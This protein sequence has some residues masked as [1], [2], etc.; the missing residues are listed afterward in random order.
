MNRLPEPHLN[1]LLRYCATL[2]CVLS[3]F[4][5]L[6]TGCTRLPSLQ[7]RS[8]SEAELDTLAT[9]LG[10]AISPQ[11]VK[12]FG[13]S[14]IYPLSDGRDAFVARAQLAQAAER[15]LD[16]QYYIWHKDMT[17]T[18]LFDALYQTANRGVRVRLLLDDNNT[19]G[20]DTLLAALDAHPKIEVRL[21]NPFVFRNVRPLDYVINFGR[22]N[23]RMHNKSF[24]ADS[25]ATIIGGRNI[26]D[27]YF[28]AADG[29]LFADLDVLAV[30]PV[31]Q[32][33]SRD[34]DRYWNS[35]S[36]YQVKGFLPQADSATLAELSRVSLRL[37][38]DSSALAYT[39]ALRNSSFAGDLLRGD[40]N[41]EWAVTHMI[42]DDPI[43][44]LGLAVP[45]SL[46]LNKLKTHM[47]EANSELNLVSPYFVPLN[48]GVETLA[49]AARRGVNVRVL[50]NALESTDVA[51]VHAG[52]A[53]H[54]KSLLRAGVSLY[55]L[56]SAGRRSATK[57][58]AGFAG[59]SSSSL[60][61]K[62]FSVDHLRVFIGSFNFDPRSANLN[63]EMGFVI[64]SPSL[65]ASI[66]SAFADGIPANAY[67][68]RLSE[69]G[70]LYWIERQG[71]TELRHDVEPGT[72]VM[73]RIG[74]SL[75]SLLPID[76][77]L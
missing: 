6:T 63:T 35:N 58:V 31:V 72:S 59:S 32:E 7:N 67:E 75:I 74:V 15:T 3:S 5:F 65:A 19:S 44:G 17:G 2:A 57:Q 51:A 68:V 55:E 41:I 37:K 10:Q 21:F 38:N 9:G 77:L 18:M 46:I 52:Y 71:I 40:L 28:G 13:R 61:S 53:K 73:A 29:V 33:V 11:V 36:S 60:H 24:T 22:A 45:D 16:V 48:K 47:G 8:V 23:R 14:G 62:T 70:E 76:W 27:E 1:I 39:E 26:G 30:G 34:F 50:T 49:E 66:S 43:K 25:Q 56:R 54:R 42:S 64:E 4:L 12:H 69:A 20:L